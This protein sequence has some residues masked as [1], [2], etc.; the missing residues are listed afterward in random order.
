MNCFENLG[1][2]M[3]NKF[4]FAI[5]PIQPNMKIPYSHIV[6]KEKRG[7]FYTATKDMDIISNWETKLKKCNWA[8]ATGEKSNV[9]VIDIDVKGNAK[10]F[11]SFKKMIEGKP[12]MPKTY[13]VKTP[14]SGLHFYFKYRSDVKSK[15]NVGLY[16]GV[17]IKTDGGYVL[18]PKSKIGDSIYKV[19][20]DT[21]IQPMPDWLVKE[22]NPQK[23]EQQQLVPTPKILL[24][25][26]QLDSINLSHARKRGQ[27]IYDKYIKQATEGTRNKVLLSMLCQM[28]DNIIPFG[29]AEEYTKAF[30]IDINATNFTLAEGLKVLSQAYKYPARLPSFKSLTEET[31]DFKIKL[32]K[33]ESKVDIDQYSIAEFL[34]ESN[35][36]I[37]HI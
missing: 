28:R 1:E 34:S 33:L 35:L 26:T 2:K 13:T 12:E 17:D 30:V 7:G 14:S 10:G 32:K 8:I 9:I 24:K 11:E 31:E 18:I 36:N 29:I 37:K 21:E 20:E 4:N 3:E 16:G 25:T 22:I 27:I 19:V 6:D 15:I 23:E 5:F